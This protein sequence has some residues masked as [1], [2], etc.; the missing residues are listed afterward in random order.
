MGKG[1]WGV[2]DGMMSRLS[3]CMLTHR[4]VIS[5]KCTHRA[6][7]IKPLA[8]AA[9]AASG[10]GVSALACALE[11]TQ[12]CRGCVR[13]DVGRLGVVSYVG[14]WQRTDGDDPHTFP[15]VQEEQGG[16][17]ALPRP[18]CR[19]YGCGRRDGSGTACRDAAQ[20]RAGKE[21][22]WG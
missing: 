19:C 6:L 5:P 4:F 8:P 11:Q 15:S 17:Q 3:V 18:A 13:G 20:R 2:G 9:F 1:G 7:I 22:G 12:S 14:S 21:V 16:R 10:G